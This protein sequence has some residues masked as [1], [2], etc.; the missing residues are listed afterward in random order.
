MTIILDPREWNCEELPR[1]EEALLAYFFKLVYM[2]RLRQLEKWGDQRHPDGTSPAVSRLAASLK[3]QCQRMAAVGQVTWMDILLEEVGEAAECDAVV[4][5]DQVMR[6]LLGD[7][8]RDLE[9]EII[10]SAAVLGA[11]YSDLCRRARDIVAEHEANAG[12][13]DEQ[14]RG[15]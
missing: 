12:S 2:E 14:M 11:W 8:E 5:V 13:L 1:A 6:S 7:T 9:S 10:Q 4:S 15:E 3:A